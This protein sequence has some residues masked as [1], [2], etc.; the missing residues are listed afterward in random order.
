MDCLSS[1]GL[2]TLA[3]LHYRGDLIEMHKLIHDQCDEQVVDNYPQQQP[4]RMR[5]HSFNLH[6]LG[7]NF[8]TRTCKWNGGS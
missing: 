4:S 6:K 5:R 8:N 2:P 3:H 7:C 1:I